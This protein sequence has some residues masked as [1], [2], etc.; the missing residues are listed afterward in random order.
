MQALCYALRSR[1]HVVKFIVHK[2]QNHF[3]P[4]IM[5]PQKQR[6]RLMCIKIQEVILLCTEME[7]SKLL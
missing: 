3:P 1:I 6:V 7:A 4:K 2:G 5:I